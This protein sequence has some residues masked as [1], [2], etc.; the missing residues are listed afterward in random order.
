MLTSLLVSIFIFVFCFSHLSYKV[1]ISKVHPF[2]NCFHNSLWMGNAL[3]LYFSKKN[4]ILLHFILIP[5]FSVTFFFFLIP[6]MQYSLISLRTLMTVSFL[7]FSSIVSLFS[8]LISFLYS[9]DNVPYWRIYS[10]PG[11]PSFS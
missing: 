6:W 3:R 2:R 9:C 10:M 8:K 5:S 4:I 1:I 11:D 7:F